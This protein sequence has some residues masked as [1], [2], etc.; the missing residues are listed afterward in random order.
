MVSRG[1][2][3]NPLQVILQEKCLKFAGEFFDRSLAA[4]RL[5]CSQSRWG[6][7]VSSTDFWEQGTLAEGL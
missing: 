1:A 6:G 5:N 2:V 4:P 3:G 7:S